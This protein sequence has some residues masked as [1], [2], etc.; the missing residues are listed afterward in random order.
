MQFKTKFDIISG[1]R[2]KAMQCGLIN[3]EREPFSVRVK[4]FYD[5]IMAKKLIAPKFTDSLGH[6][7][8]G[9][10]FQPSVDVIHHLF[11]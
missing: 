11:F 3:K 5:V 4:E 6:E 1:P 8:D 2:H 9:L 7:P 10:I